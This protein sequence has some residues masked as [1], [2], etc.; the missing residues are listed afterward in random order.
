MNIIQSIK[1]EGYDEWA[2]A[3]AEKVEK[4]PDA[5]HVR[6][7]TGVQDLLTVQLKREEEQ[8]R[9]F[10]EAE[11]ELSAAQKGTS[12][13]NQE[14]VDG[15]FSIEEDLGKGQGEII[16][17]NELRRPVDW[18]PE[19]PL[20]ASQYVRRLESMNMSCLSRNVLTCSSTGSA[21]WKPRLEGD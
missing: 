20:D 4:Y 11:A 1:P 21:M 13:A 17:S 7:S 19:P 10:E 8:F 14:E 5:F 9:D 2:K 15:N 6:R 16:E 18:E 12:N 3:A